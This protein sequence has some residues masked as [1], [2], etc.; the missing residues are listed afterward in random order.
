MCGGNS[1]VWGK[2]EDNTSTPAWVAPYRAKSAA[3]ESEA[4]F[5][6]NQMEEPGTHLQAEQVPIQMGRNSGWAPPGLKSP[7]PARVTKTIPTELE[8]WHLEQSSSGLGESSS[9]E[10]G[11]D[12]P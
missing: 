11:L 2:P 3:C 4:T 12:S 10:K 8:Q 5:W 9:P 7:D 6:T 1:P